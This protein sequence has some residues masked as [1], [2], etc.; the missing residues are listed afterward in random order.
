MLCN[1]LYEQ[2]QSEK[3]KFACIAKYRTALGLI[4]YTIVLVFLGYIKLTKEMR[5][6][7][8]LS[9]IISIRHCYLHNKLTA[10]DVGICGKIV[11]TLAGAAFITLHRK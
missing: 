3:Q 8:Q 5:Y 11:W 7:L 2:K 6:L 9:A 10:S 1:F 4:L